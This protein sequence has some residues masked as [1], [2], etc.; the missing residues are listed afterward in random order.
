MPAG[1][2]MAAVPG[3]RA[4]DAVAPMPV[5]LGTPTA[6][7]DG[8]IS[9]GAGVCTS[10]R[11]SK[12][13]CSRSIPCS[14]CVRLG[15]LCI[16]VGPSR[17]GLARPKKASVSAVAESGQAHLLAGD[18]KQE[19]QDD[20]G[21]GTPCLEED[22]AEEKT[23]SLADSID[24][25]KGPARKR[26]KGSTI[27]QIITLEEIEPSEPTVIVS[28]S[29][30]LSTIGGSVD[31]DSNASSALRREQVER[32]VMVVLPLVREWL[33]IGLRRR[34]RSLLA[35]AMALATAL[36]LDLSTVLGDK[37]DADMSFLP[38]LMLPVPPGDQ[39]VTC[40]PIREEFIPSVITSM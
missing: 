24:G 14:R 16:S 5:A 7:D 21:E 23:P 22:E 17:R 27:P 38:K 12:V 20:R 11:A 4:G 33:A 32:C 34:S 30:M 9:T 29:L 1:A 8:S 19:G 25:G 18:A 10:C 6:Y 31:N 2:I 35:R 36:D 3:G 26:A 40:V 28:H 15:M 37:G 39:L 13:R